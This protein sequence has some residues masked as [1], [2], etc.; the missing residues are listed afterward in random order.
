[1]PRARQDREPGF[2]RTLRYHVGRI[3]R[4]TLSREGVSLGTD[5]LQGRLKAHLL[6]L[7][8]QLSDYEDGLLGEAGTFTVKTSSG[9]SCVRVCVC[10]LRCVRVRRR[11]KCNIPSVSSRY[12]VLWTASPA[13][14]KHAQAGYHAHV[15]DATPPV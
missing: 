3:E 6:K 11:A 4:T 13:H 15:M 5:V 14:H 7:P 2:V 12:A 10:V 8:I 1:V 9:K